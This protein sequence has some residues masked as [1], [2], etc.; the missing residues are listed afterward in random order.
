[1][2]TVL[3]TVYF[4]LRKDLTTAERDDFARAA[5]GLGAA[6]TVVDCRVGRPAATPGRDVTDHSFDYS[7]HLEFASVAD[8]D[9]YQADPVHLAF[10]DTQSNKFERVLVF[11]SQLAKI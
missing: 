4:W 2:P 7:L 10:V 9:T 8:H 11:D 3:H 6:P 5:R 1:M